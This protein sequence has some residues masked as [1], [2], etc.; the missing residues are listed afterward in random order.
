L[1][2]HPRKRYPQPVMTERRHTTPDDEPLDAHLLRKSGGGKPVSARE[3]DELRAALAHAEQALVEAKHDNLRAHA[4]F[5]NFRKRMRNEREQEFARGNDKVLA[6][7]LTILDD[8]ERALAAPAADGECVRQGI[9]LIYRNLAALLGRYGIT[10]MEVE[11][12]PFDPMLHD[13]VARIPSDRAPE[14]TIVGVVQRGYLK[15]GEPFRPARV[16]VAVNPEESCQ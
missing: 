8:F 3:A 9:E 15:N 13:A 7:L 2:P 16:A 11:G 6:D 1:H 5:D 14:H 4:D 10:P 12:K